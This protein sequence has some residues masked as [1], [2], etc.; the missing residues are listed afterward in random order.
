MKDRANRKLIFYMITAIL[1]MAVIFILSAQSAGISSGESGGI[2]ERILRVFCRDYDMLPEAERLALFA[3]A[4]HLIRKAAHMFE[5]AVLAV[6]YALWFGQIRKER[7]AVP[8]GSVVLRLLR[9]RP[10]LS[11]L[12]CAVL[13]SVSDEIHQLFVPGRSGEVRDVLIDGAGALIVVSALRLYRRCRDRRDD[14]LD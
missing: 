13:Y 10:Y 9:N 6:L 3:T 8:E 7:A 14:V 5:Y 1:W 11:A 4:D 12:V 2:A